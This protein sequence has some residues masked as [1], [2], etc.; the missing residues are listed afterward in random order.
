MSFSE[1]LSF[2]PLRIYSFVS[3]FCLTLYVCFY[4]LDK[5]TVSP[6][7]E[8]EILSRRYSCEALKH[9]PTLYGHQ[10]LVSKGCPLCGLYMP[11]RCCGPKLQHG[12]GQDS[13]PAWLCGGWLWLWHGVTVGKTLA[14]PGY[15][16]HNCNMAPW[17]IGL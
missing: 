10:S 3:S 17:R 14:W 8:G 12:S 5:L 6:S 13:C 16:M 2:S 1:V 4:V 7:L 11:A 9:P 15:F